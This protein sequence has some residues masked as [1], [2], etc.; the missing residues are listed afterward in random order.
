[1]NSYTNSSQGR[2]KQLDFEKVPPILRFLLIFK[3]REAPI[4]LSLSLVA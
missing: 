2:I 3:G 1:L 4:S